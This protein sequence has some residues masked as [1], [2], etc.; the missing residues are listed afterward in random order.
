MVEDPQFANPCCSQVR[1]KWRP[2]ATRTD[3]GYGGGLKFLLPTFTKF[4]Q[5]EVAAIPVPFVF[6]EG[7]HG[8]KLQ[9]LSAFLR[10]RAFA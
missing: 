6:R 8:S 10:L 4:R 9:F 2:Q 3:D 7:A 1:D 5:Y